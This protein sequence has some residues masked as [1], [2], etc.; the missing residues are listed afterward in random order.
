VAEP[1]CESVWQATRSI[2]EKV[3]CVNASRGALFD[4]AIDAYGVTDPLVRKIRL[5]ARGEPRTAGDI[6]WR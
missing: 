2:R 3:T 6:D 1:D 5:A 4:A